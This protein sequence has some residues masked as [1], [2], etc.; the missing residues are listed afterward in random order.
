MS[1][2]CRASTSFRLRR[3]KPPLPT[4]CRV[5]GPWRA[6]II[7]VE[8]GRVPGCRIEDEAIPLHHQYMAATEV[9]AQLL[10]HEVRILGHIAQGRHGMNG[11]AWVAALK[12]CMGQQNSL[13][14]A[15]TGHAALHDG[16]SQ[17]WIAGVE[18]KQA[19]RGEVKHF[20]GERSRCELKVSGYGWHFRAPGARCLPCKFNPLSGDCGK[21]RPR[22]PVHIPFSIPPIDYACLFHAVHRIRRRRPCSV[23]TGLSTP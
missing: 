16:H 17:L 5:C 12:V 6:D 4:G 8:T 20:V 10:D 9:P 22:P 18:A 1:G 21:I 13:A 7:V 11:D 23:G 15:R 3:E 2:S 19:G 14:K